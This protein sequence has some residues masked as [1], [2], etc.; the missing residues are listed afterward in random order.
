[1][2]IFEWKETRYVLTHLDFSLN[3]L[4]KQHDPDVLIF[5]HSHRA[6]VR[7]QGKTLLI[8]PGETGGWVTGKQTVA[9]FDPKDKTA[10]IVSLY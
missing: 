8:N 6:E 4:I 10:D 2:F 7:F 1:P 9:L 5:G 3:S